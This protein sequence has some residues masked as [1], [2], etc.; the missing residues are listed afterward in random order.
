MGPN[1]SNPSSSCPIEQDQRSGFNQTRPL[2]IQ[3]YTHKQIKQNTSSP[4]P[5]SISHF[6]FFLLCSGEEQPFWAPLRSGSFHWK[7]SRFF[8]RICASKL[9][10]PLPC[11]VLFPEFLLGFE[12]HMAE[13]SFAEPESDCLQAWIF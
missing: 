10:I 9:Q 7:S 11:P 12:D 4:T 5:T 2:P 1:N 3:K 13:C 8:S 6:P